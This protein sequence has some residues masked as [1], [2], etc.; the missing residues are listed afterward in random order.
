MGEFG[1]KNPVA[2]DFMARCEFISL[3]CDVTQSLQELGVRRY[4]YPFDEV[5][6]SMEGVIDSVESEMEELVSLVDQHA[7]QADMDRHIEASPFAGAAIG[8][9][10]N[11]EAVTELAAGVRRFFGFCE[12]PATA[13]RVFVRAAATV[14]DVH[15]ALSLHRSLQ[16]AF[17]MGRVYLLILAEEEALQAPRHLRSSQWATSEDGL[18]FYSMDA[19]Q[20][21]RGASMKKVAQGIA[22][23]VNV[24][25]GVAQHERGELMSTESDENFSS[26][27]SSSSSSSIRTPQT[28]D[29]QLCP[30]VPYAMWSGMANTT[31]APVVPPPQPMFVSRL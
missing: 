6:L 31:S 16:D 17:P 18:L 13:P 14:T 15:L 21:S 2:V 10:S 9:P 30:K 28:L 22:Y 20:Q 29:T 5:D 25:A 23:A 7:G 26:S 3:G 12:V 24:W 19:G 4:E 8:T 11:P 1:L 27:S